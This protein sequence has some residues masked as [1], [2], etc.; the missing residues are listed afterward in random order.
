MLDGHTGMSGP[1]HGGRKQLKIRMIR[2]LVND[3]V[4]ASGLAR[5]IDVDARVVTGSLQRHNSTGVIGGDDLQFPTGVHLPV[6][7]DRS[8][9]KFPRDGGTSSG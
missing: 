6:T 3:D 2:R 1:C 4:A 5:Y 8:R 9:N 7:R